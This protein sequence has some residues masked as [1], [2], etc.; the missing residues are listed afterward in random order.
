[1]TDITT[2]TALELQPGDEIVDS[3]EF[4]RSLYAGTVRNTVIVD[5]GVQINLA[6]SGHYTRPEDHTFSVKA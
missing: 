3:G 6:P 1:M 4:P 5:K 2:K